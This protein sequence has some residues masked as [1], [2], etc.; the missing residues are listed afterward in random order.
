MR[1]RHVSLAGRATAGKA[2]SASRWAISRG[3]CGGTQKTD[4]GVDGSH[5]LRYPASHPTLLLL[6]PTWL[7]AGCRR[8]SRLRE[9]RAARTMGRKRW[10]CSS[11]KRSPGL[12]TSATW[13]GATSLAVLVQAAHHA[14][15]WSGLSADSGRTARRL[16]AASKRCFK[17]IWQEW[18]SSIMPMGSRTHN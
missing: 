16:C 11:K 5:A 7:H 4:T 18:D 13:F 3:L 10:G 12:K 9:R 6:M 17:R 14:L 2:C 8:A 15:V 1:A